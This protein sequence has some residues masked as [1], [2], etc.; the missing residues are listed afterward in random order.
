MVA[1]LIDVKSV[2]C[3]GGADRALRRS[4]LA[5]EMF[6]LVRGEYISAEVWNGLDADERYLL[7]IRAVRDVAASQPVFSHWSAAAIW[8]Y[9]IVGWW[10]RE[11]HVVVGGQSGRRTATGI[12]R[13]VVELSDDEVVEVNGFLVTSPLRT[14]CDLARS[15]SFNTAVAALDRGFAEP[16]GAAT[17]ALAVNREEFREVLAKNRGQRGIRQARAAEAFADGRSGSSGE[18]YSRVQMW[19]AGLPKPELQVEIVDLDG[20]TWHS[21]F[22]WRG[23]RHLGEFDGMVKYTRNRYLKGRDVADVVIEEKLREDAIRAASRSGMSRWT[24]PIAADLPRLERLLRKAGVGVE[25]PRAFI[26]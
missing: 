12:V 4:T 21:D 10:P 8:G 1:Q 15:A 26:T 17:D 11:V 14:L 9:P 20:R 19:R 18:S 13:H 23:Y 24:W 2:S 22:G 3:E 5:G 7:R 16:A 6:R 25:P